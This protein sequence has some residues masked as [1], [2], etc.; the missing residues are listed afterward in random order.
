MLSSPERPPGNEAML[1][2]AQSSPVGGIVMTIAV[3][4]I[5]VALVA[6]LAWAARRLLGRP[7]GTLRALAAGLLGF[8][9]AELFGRWLLPAQTGHVAAFFTVALG[10]PLVV[11]MIFIVTAEVLVPSGTGPQ[12][13]DVMRNA[14]RALA[15]SRRYSQ[16]SRIAVQHGLGPYLRGR[17][18]RQADAA[19]GRAALAASLRSALEAGGVTFT[20]LGQLLST[21]HDLLPA[22][23]T[24]ELARLQDR[25]EPAPW[26][27]VEQVITQALGVPAAE[28]FAELQPVPA[29]AASI[30]QVHK[31]RLR[32]AGPGAEVAVKVQRPG[33]RATVEQDLDILQR[34]AARLEKRT[35]W[36]RA[37]GAVGVAR[38]FAAAI[39]EELDFR[40]EARNM[41]VVAA[42]WP[43]QQRAAGSGVPVVLPALHEELCTEHVLVIEWLDGVSLRAAGRE[44]EDRGLDRAKLTSALLGSMVYQITEGG[45]FHADPHPGNV[46]LLTD[47]RLALLDFGS[48]GRLDA[49]QR[50]ALQNLL[51]AIGRGDPAALRD[52]LL[53]LVTRTV[54]IDEQQ[55]ERAL[56]QFMARHLAVGLPP[57]AEIFT[58]LFRLASRFELTIPPEIGTVL[59]A[60]ATLEGTLTE[61]SPDFDLVTQ[62]RQYAATHV[63]AQLAPETM[64]R[65]AADELLALLPVLRRLPRRLDRITGALEQGR[66]GVNVRLFADERDRRVVTDLSNQFLLTLLGAASGIVAALLIG[67]PGGPMI[68]P[69]VSLFQVIGYNLLLVASILVLRVLFT[70]FRYR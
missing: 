61:L 45:V 13:V 65:T 27:Q 31:A 5:S 7:V 37:V 4:V 32:G 16:I 40:V 69:G 42:T 36:A 57:S 48:V 26:E 50:A 28:V 41:A 58:D 17:R 38:G 52:A 59:R 9:A 2:A 22:E 49:Q 34:L 19:G 20:K 66:L 3:L 47:G 12:P 11:A 46:M 53:E 10:I 23:F 6:G 44:I 25:A 1:L 21:R 35:R 51:L 39:R 60:L 24:A 8:A 62:A 67:A 63:T 15:R 68:A 14:R 56:G 55:L 18:L 43:G 33:I 29:A 64:P 70:I 30:A 54:D